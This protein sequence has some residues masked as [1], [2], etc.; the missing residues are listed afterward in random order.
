[1][2]VDADELLLVRRQLFGI[3]LKKKKFDVSKVHG[4]EE[5]REEIRMGYV[6]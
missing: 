3:A 4:R 5:E 6:R 2:A 1:V